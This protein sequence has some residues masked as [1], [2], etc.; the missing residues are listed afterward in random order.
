MHLI[1]N[2]L[3]RQKLQKSFEK[4]ADCMIKERFYHAYEGGNYFLD[5]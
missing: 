4:R 5:V 1:E 3:G 2:G